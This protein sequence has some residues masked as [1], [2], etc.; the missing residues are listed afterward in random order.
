MTYTITALSHDHL[1]KLLPQAKLGADI[2]ELRQAYF[3][4]GSISYCLLADDIPVFAG[5]IV[6]MK[7]GRGEVWMLPTPFFF[8]HIR[9][10]YKRMQYTIPM[11]AKEGS[12]RRVQATCADTVSTLLFKHLG[13]KY[14]G[15]LGKFGPHGESCHMYARLF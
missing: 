4:T 11:M 5:G 6:N 10:C 12:F 3:S 9:A 1:N 2:V 7:W 15:T 8:S 13:F 14:E